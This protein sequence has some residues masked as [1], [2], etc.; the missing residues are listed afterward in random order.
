MVYGIGCDLCSIA[1]M[2]KSLLGP[3]GAGFVQ[4]GCNG[5]CDHSGAVP[6]ADLVLDDEHRPDAALFRAHHR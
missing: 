4:P 6:V 1:R 5:R 2:E 3:H